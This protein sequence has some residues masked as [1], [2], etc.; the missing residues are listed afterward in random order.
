M[1]S[2]GVPSSSSSTLHTTSPCRRA[3]THL[4]LVVNCTPV[5]MTRGRSGCMGMQGCR[6]TT[7]ALQG[8]GIRTTFTPRARFGHSLPPSP[9]S[10]CEQGPSAPFHQ[11][12]EE[13]H[14]PLLQH[15][16]VLDNGVTLVGHF[17]LQLFQLLDLLPGL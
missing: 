13:V 11:V 5:L 3:L 2:T 7:K 17:L 1:G 12:P 8:K 4:T 15:G 10:A 14:D 6:S 9:A 16:P